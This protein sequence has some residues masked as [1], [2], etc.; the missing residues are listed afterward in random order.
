[1][2]PMENPAMRRPSSDLL[3]SRPLVALILAAGLAA[4]QAP[5]SARGAA[6]DDDKPATL[7]NVVKGIAQTVAGMIKATPNGPRVVRI[8]GFDDKF[9]AEKSAV[10]IKVRDLLT[11]SLKAEGI[12]IK[13]KAPL[14]LEG[15]SQTSFTDSDDEPKR[16]V[17]IILITYELTR[18]G[19]DKPLLSSK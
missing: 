15:S 18:Q 4:M 16:E 8:R 9:D 12:E 5:G 19:D 17:P 11:V 6:A 7:E 2:H 3:V 10:G 13:V 14:V 1:R